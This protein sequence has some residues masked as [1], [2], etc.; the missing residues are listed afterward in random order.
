MT[1]VASG[2]GQRSP[3]RFGFVTSG[4][5]PGPTKR[6]VARGVNTTNRMMMSVSMMYSPFTTDLALH[7]G[8]RR[9]CDEVLTGHRQF[10]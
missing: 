8:A 10:R 2:A 7:M 3:A 6:S 1:V 5:S 4:V 9:V